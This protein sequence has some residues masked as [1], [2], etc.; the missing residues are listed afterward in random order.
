MPREILLYKKNVF[1]PATKQGVR[2][3]KKWQGLHIKELTMRDTITD[4]AKE[5]KMRDTIKEFKK[6][7]LRSAKEAQGFQIKVF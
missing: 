7:T 3:A 2:D 4:D 6:G 1:L 5:L